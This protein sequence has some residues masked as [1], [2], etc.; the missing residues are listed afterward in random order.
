MAPW[1]V[2]SPLAFSWLS[3]LSSWEP[4]PPL[5]VNLFTFSCHAS[6][7]T[8]SLTKNRTIPFLF[9]S[10]LT[11]V[12]PSLLL[13]PP[14]PCLIYTPSLAYRCKKAFFESPCWVFYGLCSFMV[15]FCETLLPVEASWGPCSFFPFVIWNAYQIKGFWGSVYVV[16]LM[17]DVISVK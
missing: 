13:S 15:H 6:L 2:F 4:L 8:P 10:S 14:F 11:L 5:V 12:S 9:R 16:V 1:I 3:Y 7:A 17:S